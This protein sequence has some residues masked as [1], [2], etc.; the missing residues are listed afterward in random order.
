VVTP[1]NEAIRFE[2]ERAFCRYMAREHGRD[3]D[4][5]WRTPGGTSEIARYLKGE[6][7]AA[8][9]TLWTRSGASWNGEVERAFMNRKLKREDA[10]ETAWKARQMFLD[11]DVGAGDADILFGGGWY[12]H[13]KFARMGC[14]VPSGVQTRHP[15]WFERER[16]VL[17]PGMSGETWYDRGDCYYGTCLTTFGICYNVDRLAELGYGTS[18]S[19]PLPQR[20][21]DLGDPRLYGCVGAA[22]PSK[23]GSITKCFEMLI[24][25]RMAE[26]VA[27]A[28][29]Q[30]G[31]TLDQEQLD[32][33]VADG[34]NQA[35]LLVR[36]IGGNAQYFTFS[37]SK[38][39]LSVARGDVAVGMC[40]DF[41]GRTQAE[42]EESRLGRRT[43]RYVTPLAGSSVSA[44]PIAIL[45]GAPHRELAEMFVDFSLSREG[46][47][48]W[49]YRPGTEGGPLKYALR[50]LPIRRDLY[51][52]ED[53]EK[54]SDPDARPF[55]EA[56]A[57]TYHPEWTGRLFNLMRVLV[58]VMAIDCHEELR[59][60]WSAIL[61]AGGP[62]AT[63][64]AMEAFSRLPVSYEES[65][66]AARR[67]GSGEER[68]VLMRE[69]AHFFRAS[70]AEAETKARA[71]KGR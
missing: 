5:D 21:E 27:A 42:W 15:E 16:P 30:S 38:V 32:K 46:Q 52:K 24:Q 25:Q 20:W 55:A 4:I 49:N 33:A 14:T 53:R 12:D 3:V 19:E 64:D 7:T 37:A 40:I 66:D 11:S 45:R 60:A 22:D 8:F 17:S 9:R 10:S 44:D 61:D 51:T 58:R 36:K 34:W 54:M 68:V 63:P 23:S 71:V 18:A 2:F 67:I 1:H 62:D 59:G 57:F 39:P 69:W 48:L 31:G 70:Y 56:E 50:R 26:S 29:A 47:Q 65:G 41:Y 35:L 28:T 43:M 13:N 6:Y